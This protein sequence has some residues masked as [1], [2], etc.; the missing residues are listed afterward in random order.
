MASTLTRKWLGIV[1][2]LAIAAATAV[3]LMAQTGGVTGTAKG[4]DGKN[5]AGYPILIERQEIKGTYKTK[6]NK[7]GNYVYIGLPIGTYK[8]ILE[9]PTGHQ[10]TYVTKHVGLGDPT[11]ID[12]D[13]AKLKGAQQ[14]LEAIKEQ[15]QYGALK[16]QFDAATAL[17]NQGKYAEA[18]DAFAKAVPLANGDKNKQ[19]VLENEANAYFKAGQ[20]DKSAQAIQQAIQKDPNNQSL[21]AA[22]ANDYVKMGN[23]PEA[24]KEFKKAGQEVNQKALEQETKAAKENKEFKGLKQ[25]FDAG[26]ALYNQGQFAQAAQT[27]EK[28]IP[29][30]KEKNL[31]VVLSRAADSYAKA[32]EYDKAVA[33]YQKAITADPTN[34]GYMNNLGS[35]YG[36]M[37]K[38]DLA[39]QE[40]EKAAQADPTNA[41]R[42]YYNIGAIETNA[43][44]S[45]QAAAAFKKATQLDPNYADAYFLEAQALMGKAKV[46]SSGKVVPAP[47][48][49]EA[50]QSYLKVAPTGKYASAAQQMLQTLT[51][52]VQ[53]KY[54]KH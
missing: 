15:K 20:F 21:H 16:Q 38:P 6:T 54:S 42:Y 12:F 45:D 41:A 35:L 19:A 27:F 32:H 44:K 5:L 11:E 10:L 39:V 46:N 43:G 47:G 53:T 33:D 22:L 31:P 4:T 8:V 37:G 24:A 3:P 48:T 18:G 34:G 9:D 28:A 49:V 25:T 36:Q 26:N 50:L 40:F 7:H 29:M 17:Y 13:L 2:A 14:A 52:K 30:A 1:F 51:G 23:M